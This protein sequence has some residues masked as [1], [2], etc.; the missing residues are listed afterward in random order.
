MRG[1]AEE[2]HSEASDTERQGCSPVPQTYAIGTLAVYSSWP[3]P[4]HP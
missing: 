2:L 1:L 4:L 3:S